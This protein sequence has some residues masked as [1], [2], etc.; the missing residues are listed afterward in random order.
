MSSLFISGHLLIAISDVYELVFN[1]RPFTHTIR[2][3]VWVGP[4]KSIIYSAAPSLP[5][6]KYSPILSIPE[7]PLENAINGVFFL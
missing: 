5:K 7:P 4:R 6:S 3:F 1:F 2:T